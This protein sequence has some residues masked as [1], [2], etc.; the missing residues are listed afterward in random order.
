M[1][2]SE[3]KASVQHTPAEWTSSNQDQYANADKA[4]YHSEKVRNQALLLISDTR[5]QTSRDQDNVN[6]RLKERLRLVTS[7][8]SDLQQE[9][10]SNKKETA[11]LEE[12]MRQ[13]EHAMKET[14][15]PMRT[16]QDCLKNREN[17]QGIDLVK[18]E[19]EHSLDREV[20]NI[21]NY[22]ERMR[23]TL[24]IANSQLDQNLRRQVQLQEDLDNKDLALDIDKICFELRN[25]SKNIALQAGVENIDASGSEPESWRRFSSKNREE[26]QS[27][28]AASAQVRSDIEN[29]LNTASSELVSH[30]NHSNQAF[31]A[32]VEECEEAQNQLKTKLSMIQ[33]ELKDQNIYIDKIKAAIRAKGPPLKV[34]QTRIEKRSHRPENENCNDSPHIKMVEEVGT[35]HNTIEQLNAKLAQ[36]QESKGQLLAVKTNSLR[37]DKQKCLGIRSSFPYHM[38]ADIASKNPVFYYTYYN[39]V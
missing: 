16:A 39:I 34:S 25:N 19:V 24:D 21:R 13:L 14:E 3:N 2:E 29:L 11:C 1:A 18:D 26:S 9:L 15:R 7:W 35:I 8:R 5:C 4:R 32:R 20:E 38:R 23:E 33:K 27:A 30:W 28:R 36:A 6:F 22:Q 31:K 17:R 10:N 37:I 12:K